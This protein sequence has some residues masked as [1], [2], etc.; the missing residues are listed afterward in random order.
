MVGGNHSRNINPDMMFRQI[1]GPKPAKTRTR[2]TTTGTICGRV[3]AVW[4]PI[5]TR[6]T[7]AL[8]GNSTGLMKDSRHKPRSASVPTY[9]RPASTRPGS[10][11]SQSMPGGAARR[12]LDGGEEFVRAV[13][14][15][16]QPDR[17]VE[18]R[19]GRRPSS[20]SRRGRGRPGRCSTMWRNASR[21]DMRGMVTSRMT[22]AIRSCSR[23][24]T[25]TASAPSS[26]VSTRIAGAVEDRAA[27]VA[28]HLLVVHEQDVVRASAASSRGLTGIARSAAPAGP[29]PVGRSGERTARRSAGSA[30]GR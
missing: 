9:G 7:K 28:D 17:A 12:G 29:R 21:P 18:L 13:R 4:A 24:N 23:V 19:R 1:L 6:S 5:R 25:S 3:D 26:A 11:T 30:G 14:L 16:E 27:E 15:A 22:S 8:L 20:R 2:S 10:L